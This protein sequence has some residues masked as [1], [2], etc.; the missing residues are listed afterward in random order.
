[1][2]PKAITIK[3]NVDEN[4]AA[5]ISVIPG[6]QLSDRQ[7]V[8]ESDASISHKSYDP[9]SQPRSHLQI[10]NIEDSFVFEE[11]K[12]TNYVDTSNQTEE[13]D[14]SFSMMSAS[15]IGTHILGD[16]LSPIAERN[17]QQIQEEENSE[18]DA[19]EV[20]ALVEKPELM[21]QEKP[22]QDEALPEVE[23]GEE[24][25][26]QPC[27]E[28]EEEGIAES[29]SEHGS[30][31]VDAAESA[32]DINEPA[33][34]EAE[35]LSDDLQNDK[36][37]KP[38]ERKVEINRPTPI[39][40]P[41]FRGSRRSSPRAAPLIVAKLSPTKPRKKQPIKASSPSRS[42]SPKKAQKSEE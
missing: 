7:D 21:Q 9:E 25:V 33:S 37:E 13:T 28:Q 2:S 20:D 38:V 10:S 14:Q 5:V 32:T 34:E 1:M 26:S 36:V 29:A 19:A 27:Q 31:A 16:P 30:S 18:V 15:A 40:T 42:P 23:Q 6:E 24:H 22:E 41:S 12:E 3:P 11:N 8:M 39:D 4:T 17:V 35:Q